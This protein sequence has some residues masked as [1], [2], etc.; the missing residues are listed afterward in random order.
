MRDGKFVIFCVDDDPDVL[1]SLQ[2]VLE[3]NGYAFAS[4]PG[5]EAALAAYQQAQPDL[6]VVD[7]MMEEVDAG[8]GL[9]KRLK[10]EGC[11]VPVFMLSAVGQ[12]L[13]GNI[14]ARDLGI[15]GVF[16]KP[17]QTQDLLNTLSAKLRK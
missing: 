5:A 11:R 13:E 15:D 10:Q 3:A 9:V 6:V 1:D 4:A 7:L 14:D 16:Q 8:I 2:V 12:A 17:V